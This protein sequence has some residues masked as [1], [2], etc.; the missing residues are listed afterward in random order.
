MTIRKCPEDD[1]GYVT[2]PI[3]DMSRGRYRICH[4]ANTGSIPRTIQD[5]SRGRYRKC[6]EDDTGNVMQGVSLRHRECH[7]DNAVMISRTRQ[8]L[9]SP[10]G[11]SYFYERF[12]CVP[13]HSDCLNELLFC[14]SVPQGGTGSHQAAL[15]HVW[16]LEVVVGHLVLPLGTWGFLWALGAVVGHLML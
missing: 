13:V 2:R 7:D 8:R 1:T 16:S 12:G 15:F 9:R 5:M 10:G 4:E 6:H 14:D 11:Q 3:Q